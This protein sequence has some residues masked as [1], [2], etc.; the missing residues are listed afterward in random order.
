VYPISLLVENKPCLVVGGRSMA[1]QKVKGLLAAG[2]VVTV[3]AEEMDAEIGELGVSTEKRP[4]REGD[5][6]N[7]L[8]VVAA[9][10]DPQ[11][12]EAVFED[13]RATGTLVNAVDNPDS[14]DF[15]LP[16]LFHRGALS[17]AIST[18]GSS[19]ALA[20]WVR[21]RLSDQ[22]DERFGDIVE[23]VATT[24]DTVRQRGIST[25]GLPWAEF[26]DQLVAA[27]DSGSGLAH[28]RALCE[29][30]LEAVLAAPT[31]DERGAAE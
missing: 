9:T 11:V 23:L 2:A 1:V 14:C 24:R 20:S 29:L 7:F 3:V 6:A 22:L 28:C 13:A 12:D 27:I 15:Y 17:V 25:E 30:W 21:E 26:I 10:G 19:P 4:F 5:T 8:L 16:A 31:A 18:G